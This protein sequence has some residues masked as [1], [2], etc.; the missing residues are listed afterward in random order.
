M[1]TNFR[2]HFFSLPFLIHFAAHERAANH[3]R[4]PPR[5][6]NSSPARTAGITSHHNSHRRRNLSIPCRCSQAAISARHKFHKNGQI[7]RPQ[8]HC[9]HR[10]VARPILFFYCADGQ[11]VCEATQHIGDIARVQLFV[12]NQWGLL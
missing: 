11:W 7:D 8:V 9:L 12:F 2:F 6:F 3:H 1:V 10:C 4:G 5:R